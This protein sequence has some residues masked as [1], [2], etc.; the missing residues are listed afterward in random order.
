MVPCIEIICLWYVHL[1]PDI[2]MQMFMCPLY[3]GWVLLCAIIIIGL[4]GDVTSVIEKDDKTYFGY[5]AFGIAVSLMTF[6]TLPP[7]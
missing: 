1:T 4:S 3:G 7:M 2:S 6:F 5:S